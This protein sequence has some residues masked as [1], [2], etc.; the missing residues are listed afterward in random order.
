MSSKNLKDLAQAMLDDL[1][2]SAEKK[3]NNPLSR[4]Q[5]MSQPGQIF[6]VNEKRFK[7]VIRRT[8]RFEERS[9]DARKKTGADKIKDLQQGAW[10][11]Y[12]KT[13]AKTFTETLVKRSISNEWRKDPV[14]SKKSA[15]EF[16]QIIDD[17]YQTLQNTKANFEGSG[18][19]VFIITKFKTLVDKG[20]S[21][22]KN[23]LQKETKRTFTKLGGIGAL[24]SKKFGQQIGHAENGEGVASSSFQLV[25]SERLIDKSTASAEDRAKIQ[26]IVKKLRQQAKITIEHKDLVD[27]DGN[28]LK[29][30]IPVLTYQEAWINQNQARGIEATLISNFQKELGDIVTSENSLSLRDKIA[31]V[32]FYNVA[33][34]KSPNKKIVGRKNKVEKSNSKGDRSKTIKQNS[35]VPIVSGSGLKSSAVAPKT[36]T[37]RSSGKTSMFKLMAMLNEKLPNTVRSNMVPPGLTNVTGRFANSVKVTDIVQ[38][39][40]G[41]PSIQYTYNKSPYQ[42]FEVGTGRA[43]WANTERDPRKLID[44]SIR[45]IAAQMAIGRFYTRRR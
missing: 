9:L 16:N 28:L 24:G 39:P 5:L 19:K 15:E 22:V 2:K 25:R 14:L 27:D 32:I 23:Y 10:E 36:R 34:K 6:V 33:G 29:T 21:T 4:R 3:D 41:Y 8:I 43:P 12:T 7:D 38:T 13:L 30:Y 44:R 20:N 35:S 40:K 31:S 1:A 18:N 45:E 26:K 42:I 17:Y 37:R 11:E